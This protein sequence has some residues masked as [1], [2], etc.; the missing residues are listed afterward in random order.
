MFKPILM[1]ALIASVG[2]W[3][4]SRSVT[5]DEFPLPGEAVTAITRE[6]SRIAGYYEAN[7]AAFL[8]ALGP[9]FGALSEDAKKMMFASIVSYQIAPL[10]PSENKFTMKDLLAEPGLDCDAYALLAAQLFQ[11]W[12]PNSPLKIRMVG[13]NDG[14]VGNHAQLIV[15]G[16]GES[17]LLDPTVGLVAIASFNQILRGET[18]TA[19]KSWKVRDESADLVGFRATVEKALRKGEYR[20]TDLLYFIGSALKWPE[21][22]ELRK[23]WAT[24]Q[25]AFR[26]DKA[27]AP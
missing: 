3:S 9:E 16:K 15:E 10:G 2:L 5:A 1:M 27:S 6:P 13:W 24:P 14:A 11:E 26:A 7:R 23:G 25:N 19:V 21:M 17:L 22:I 18:I 12:V 8:N 4:F 20:P